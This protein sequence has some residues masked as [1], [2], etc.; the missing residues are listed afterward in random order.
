MQFPSVFVTLIGSSFASFKSFWIVLF[1][2][3]S[4]VSSMELELDRFNAYLIG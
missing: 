1:S 2:N 4:T 3:L